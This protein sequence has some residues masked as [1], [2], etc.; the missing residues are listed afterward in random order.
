MWLPK[1]PSPCKKI[2]EKNNLISGNKTEDRNSYL[3]FPYILCRS[4]Q[5]DGAKRWKSPHSDEPFEEVISSSSRRRKV[6][7]Y[8]SRM[9]KF[10]DVRSWKNYFRSLLSSRFLSLIRTIAF[11]NYIAWFQALH[12]HKKRS[13]SR[14][15]ICKRR[16]DA[17]T[18]RYILYFFGQGYFIFIRKKVEEFWNR[19]LWQMAK[20][21]LWPFQVIK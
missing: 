9:G 16:I 8:I 4:C 3:L 12:I 14:K 19:Y 5:S 11:Q 10:K 15:E 13:E 7:D 17:A 6:K 18:V 21:L 2:E 1:L 20:Q